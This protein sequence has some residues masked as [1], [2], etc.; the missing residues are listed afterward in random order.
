MPDRPEAATRLAEALSHHGLSWSEAAARM[1]VTKGTVGQYVLGRRR[2]TLDWLH[3][4]AT[5]L[6]IDPHELD[7]RLAPWRPHGR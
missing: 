3:A 7:E 5:A 1:G 4:A 2:P 6:G